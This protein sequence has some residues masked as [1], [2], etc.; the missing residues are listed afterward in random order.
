MK[1]FIQSNKVKIT[2]KEALL[3]F[4]IPTSQ[5]NQI[6][7]CLELTIEDY[8]LRFNKRGSVGQRDQIPVKLTSALS[9]NQERKQ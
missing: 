2:A 4:F 5:I 8:D 7:S 1:R 3:Y 6:G 9:L